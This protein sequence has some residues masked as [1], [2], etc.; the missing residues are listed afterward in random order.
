[1]AHTFPDGL[2]SSSPSRSA[3]HSSVEVA[4]LSTQFLSNTLLNEQGN[5]PP[6]NPGGQPDIKDV[7]DANVGVAAR[8]RRFPLSLRFAP[9]KDNQRQADNLIYRKTQRIRDNV[10]V[11]ERT[12]SFVAAVNKLT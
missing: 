9:E 3:L 2:P 7:C 1:V 5:P 12:A 11:G 10:L 6:S 8:M 4:V